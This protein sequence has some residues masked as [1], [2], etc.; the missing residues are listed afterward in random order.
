M[1]DRKSGRNTDGTFG[2][3]NPSKPK[4]ATHKANRGALALL[5]GDAAPP[6]QRTFPVVAAQKSVRLKWG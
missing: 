5:D 4:G 6:P 2:P 3:G 1:K